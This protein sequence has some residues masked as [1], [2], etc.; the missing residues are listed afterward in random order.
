[1]ILLFICFTALVWAQ[2]PAGTPCG[3]RPGVFPPR[4]ICRTAT[5]LPLA[6]APVPAYA[7]F[8][9][10]TFAGDLVLTVGR[11]GIAAASA[12]FAYANGA[13][14]VTT[15]IETNAQKRAQRQLLPRDPLTEGIELMELDLG[16]DGTNSPK[17]PERFVW[18]FMD[19]YGGCLPS[20]IHVIG[21][22]V[23]T[24]NVEDYTTE[25]RQYNTNMYVNGWM[26]LLIEFQKFNKLPCNVNRTVKVIFMLS[27]GAEGTPGT[28]G[29][30]YQYYVGHM[31]KLAFIRN[32]NVQQQVGMA[33]WEYMGLMATFINTTYYL[34][35]RNPSADRGDTAQ[36]QYLNFT[37]S[38][39]LEIGNAPAEAAL[40]L[41]Q[42]TQ[43]RAALNGSQLFQLLPAQSSAPNSTYID[44]SQN[45]F[46][47]LQID[48]QLSWGSLQYYQLALGGMAARFKIFMN[49]H[50]NYSL[51]F[52]TQA[53]REWLK[54]ALSR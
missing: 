44:W 2:V 30:L 35:Q 6:N 11:A 51:P 13:S 18:R 24:G 53:G 9:R 27:A 28:P 48:T 31:A 12:E 41:H 45:S 54:R 15:S 50:G 37:I 42:A 10:T 34:S 36:L 22:N 49:Q 39:T 16:L 3:G 23:N 47:S 4:T 7:R 14:V 17:A 43:L 32:Q 33:N 25:E 1:M 5:L 19:Q 21:Q 38:K 46:V 26:T 40:A 8:D 20:Q 29:V 52:Y